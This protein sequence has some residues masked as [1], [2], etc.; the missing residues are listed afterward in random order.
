[1]NRWNSPILRAGLVALILFAVKEFGL[2]IE[3]SSLSTILDA[4]FV[5]IFG[6]G[7]VNNPTDKEKF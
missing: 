5:L 7:I 3:E 2:N 4:L 1:M 6:V